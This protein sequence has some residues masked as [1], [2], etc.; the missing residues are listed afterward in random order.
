MLEAERVARTADNRFTFQFR[1]TG[2]GET[3]RGK[4]FNR[5]HENLE[6]E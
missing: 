3:S 4:E 5:H 6:I 2:L 1:L